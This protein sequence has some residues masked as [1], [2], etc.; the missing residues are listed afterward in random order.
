MSVEFQFERINCGDE[1]TN[2]KNTVLAALSDL[3]ELWKVTVVGLRAGHAYVIDVLGPGVRWGDCYQVQP[4]MLER[5]RRDL[6]KVAM[7]GGGHSRGQ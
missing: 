3:D 2:I 6:E 5:I 4:N 1:Q 7:F